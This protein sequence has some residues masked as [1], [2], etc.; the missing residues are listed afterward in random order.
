MYCI[1]HQPSYLFFKLGVGEKR[2]SR[3]PIESFATNG[4]WQGVVSAL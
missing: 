4:T 3:I 1:L 2:N